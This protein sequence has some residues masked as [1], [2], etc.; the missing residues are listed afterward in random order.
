M[1]FRL[2]PT[3]AGLGAIQPVALYTFV[4]Q[5]SKKINVCNRTDIQA[6]FGNATA[7]GHCGDSPERR[8]KQ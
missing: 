7:V 1:F 8:K 5:L 2:R 3:G 4:K 6:Y